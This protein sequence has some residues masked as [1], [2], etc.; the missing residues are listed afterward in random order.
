MRAIN[1]CIPRSR[2]LFNTIGKFLIVENKD[3]VTL[4]IV[5]NFFHVDLF[6]YIPMPKGG[7][8]IHLM[9]LPSMWGRKG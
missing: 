6:L 9:D 4:K 3:R 5:K 1:F 2:S 7:F 8:N